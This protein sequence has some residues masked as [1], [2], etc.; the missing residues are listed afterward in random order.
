[1]T[2]NVKKEFNP[3]TKFLLIVAVF[4]AVAFSL[5]A[6]GVFGN[7]K[8]GLTL[9]VNPELQQGLAA[10]W[11]FDSKDMTSTTALDVSGGGFAGTI[12]FDDNTVMGTTTNTYDSAG[13]YQW[14]A[15]GDVTFA[16]VACWGAGGGGGD[17]QPQGG[18]IGGGGGGGGAYA[19]STVSI[20]GGTTYEIVVGQAGT[21]GSGNGNGGPGGDST[22]NS[23]T[24][25]ADGG[26]GGNSDSSPGT[27]G[28]LANSTGDTESAGGDGG[29]G[30]DS[31]DLG[32][33]GGGAGGPNGTGGTG[34][35]GGVPTSGRGG[36]GGTGNNGSG[37]AGGTGGNGGNGNPGT[38]NTTGGGGGGGGD[39]SSS[40]A[41]GGGYGGGGG[42]GEGGGGAGADGACTVAYFTTQYVDPFATST[43]G[44]LGQA[45]GF[46]G[47]SDYIDIG[48][49]GSG[50]QTVAFWVKA[51]TTT[52]NLNIIDIDGTDK[53][54][55]DGSSNIVATSF[56]SSTIYVNGSTASAAI[57]TGDWYHVAITTSG[58]NAS[59]FDIGRI[60]GEGYF[61]GYIDDVRLYTNTL[62]K[63][64]ITRLYNLGATTHINKTLPTNPDLENGLLAHWTFDGK[65]MEWG[66]E[67]RTGNGYDGT[68]VGFSATTTAPGRIGQGLRFDGSNTYVNVN[69]STGGFKTVPM[70]MST[71][72]KLDVLSST[73][74][75]EQTLLRKNHNMNP[76]AVWF[77]R[78]NTSDQ[79]EFAAIS[80]GGGSSQF[81]V[82]DSTV[83]TG[84]WYHAVAIIDSNY[85][86]YIYVNGVLQAD[87]GNIGS[88]YDG[89]GDLRI[90][91]FS[92][93]EVING[94]EDDAR[95]YNRVLSTEEI[96][97]L[98]QL[99][100]T[101]HVNTTV[102]S[103]PDL[104]SGLVG[105]WTF[106]GK[107][108]YQNAADSS[109]YGHH[110]I[111]TD[112]FTST[113]TRPGHIGQA[114]YFGTNDEIVQADMDASIGFSPSTPFTMTAWVNWETNPD[115]FARIIDA[116]SSSYGGYSMH[117]WSTNTL[118][119]FVEDSSHL[120]DAGNRGST[121]LS[122]NT[123]YFTACV[124]DGTT[125]TPF[126]NA[127]E[128]TSLTGYT[129][130]AAQTSNLF[131]IGD[132]NA[133]RQWNG[134]IDDVR[135]YNRALSQ[136][137][138]QRLYDLGR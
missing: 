82:S 13:T 118:A 30:N 135:V 8:I 44:V 116:F 26:L 105:H 111:L 78:I 33:G 28:S 86:M 87:T 57:T 2:R 53:I 71:W 130:G 38:A 96:Q 134:L 91:A 73:R 100:A 62:S 77:F 113:T 69:N 32:A 79:I 72:F 129:N 138:L 94:I 5:Y 102:T 137:E 81:I 92:T 110:A 59:D 4:G 7:T 121:V 63:G 29:T 17:G 112:G 19:A 49:I 35:N 85:D 20:T 66:A 18:G 75:A 43:V 107:Y 37:G 70:T 55:T 132:R 36:N 22:F 52:A 76:F 80:S 45:V 88:L 41:A 99:G 60:E 21:A 126:I 61:G 101:T 12:M 9:N 1:M 51:A 16:D 89:T 93:S 98:Y 23:T 83:T 136:Q 15:P 27:G 117:I 124:Y 115:G 50:I 65:D 122:A 25:V 39:T 24:V 90:G 120:N 58:V 125:M 128:E 131:G 40:G 54:E 10:H 6:L 14:K 123:W 56:P 34:S 108:M 46:D 67:D 104:N 64:Q 95:F 3:V 103:N 31:S 97:R 48:N 11:T 47:V 133:N 84:Q 114:L 68:L 109:G 119:C 74:S 106:D 127:Q 42:G